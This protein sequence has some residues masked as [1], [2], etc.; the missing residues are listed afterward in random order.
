MHGICALFLL[1]YTVDLCKKQAYKRLFFSNLDLFFVRVYFV[2]YDTI[3]YLDNMKG[4]AP[5]T[6][7]ASILQDAFDSA[8]RA[9]FGGT[10]PACMILVHRKGRAHG[11]F[12]AQQFQRIGSDDVIDEIALNPDTMNRAPRVVLSTLV[13]EMVHL[14]Q[15]HFG[16]PSRAAYHNKEWASKMEDVGLMP[17][18]TGKP[19]GKRTGQRVSHYIEQGGRYDRWVTDFLTPERL[20]T[21]ASTPALKGST[22]KSKSKIKYSCGPHQAWGKPGLSIYCRDCER[23]MKGEELEE[24]TQD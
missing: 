21:W 7:T 1:Q 2:S 9:L 22:K 15:F 5:T 11:Y 23:V 13:H 4:A 17:S 19:D 6:H 16:K 12:W 20:F 18:D 14:W 8:N 24:D 3:L 10:L